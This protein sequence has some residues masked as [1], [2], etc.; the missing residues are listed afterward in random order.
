MKKKITYGI[1]IVIIAL[2]IVFNVTSIRKASGQYPPAAAPGLDTS[3]LVFYGRIQPA[4]KEIDVGPRTAGIVRA[5]LIREG[6]PVREGQVLCMFDDAV[7]KADYAV[8]LSRVETSR[9]A[10]AISAEKLVRSEPLTRS[11]SITESEY[12]QLKLKKE[13]DEAAIAVRVKEAELA[14]AKLK[15]RRVEA[16]VDGIVYKYDIRVGEMFQ[17][18]DRNRIIIG[19]PGL[20]LCCD[21]EALWSGRFDRDKT[22]LVFHAETGEL[23]G[24]GYFVSAS[25]YLRPK[26]V[27][28]E[29]A[30]E[31]LSALYQEIILR[32]APDRPGLPIGLPV[33]VKEQ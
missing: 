2:I 31:R 13:L 16:P 27:A 3:A 24:K 15:R 10:A 5:V 26:T 19:P 20:E 33:M 21:L 6:E 7:E 29:D 1:L 18:G 14:E 11:R 28:T 30:K 4:G 17:P 12:L 9:K 8:A 25:R 22:Y 32:F 23:L